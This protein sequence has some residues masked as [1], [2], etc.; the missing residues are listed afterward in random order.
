MKS[1]QQITHK[2]G[3]A[4]LWVLVFAIVG[5]FFVR[6]HTINRSAGA[7]ERISDD[8][9]FLSVLKAGLEARIVTDRDGTIIYCSDTA[10]KTCGYNHG[11]LEGQKATVLMPD[12]YIDKHLQSFERSINATRIEDKVRIIRCELKLK[13][14]TEKPVEVNERVTEGPN[15]R[16]A[17][18]TITPVESIEFVNSM[19][20]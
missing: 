12:R 1:S 10:A 15:G 8:E 13:D 2:L 16:L 6:E 3:G 11:E 17:V 18:V 20:K 9:I 19:N 7:F 4:L 5:A 14:G